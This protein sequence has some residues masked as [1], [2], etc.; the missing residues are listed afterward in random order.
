MTQNTREYRFN[1]SNASDLE[2][3]SGT[4]LNYPISVRDDSNQ[5]NLEPAFRRFDTFPTIKDIR[6]FSMIG[7]QRLVPD[8]HELV[9][10][11]FIKLYLTSAINEIEM[12]MGIFLSSAEQTVITDVVEGLF[13]PRFTGLQLQ[14][15]PVNQIL[16]VKLKSVHAMS[17]N[18]VN[19]L[20][21]P[22]NW[23]S[24]RNRRLNIMAD[25]GNIRTQSGTSGGAL[26]PF[27][28]AYGH[29]PW[30]PNAVEIQVN[31]GFTE[32]RFP[33]ILKELVIM[34]T[35]IGL[36]NDIIPMLFPFSSTSVAIDGVSQSSGL[37]GP[38]FLMTRI[39][40]LE[41]LR[42]QKKAAI[43]A[44]LGNSLVMTY[45]NT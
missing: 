33:A 4:W 32:D 27:I 1:F 37:P 25:I 21:I 17:D 42:D 16:S 15:Y 45:V 35:S 31:V 5:N 18:P 22:P 29:G 41:K 39:G 20:D 2:P 11:D 26:V 7:L 13:G 30:R 8:V 9:S 34:Q 36:L 44:A 12:S 23:I 19:V 40:M 43:K 38:Q 28:G 3:Y 6:D 10:D 24:F 14:Q